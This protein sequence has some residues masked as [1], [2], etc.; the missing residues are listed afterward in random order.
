MSVELGHFA[1]ILAFALSLAQTIVPL[2]GVL[3]RD[4]VLIG[5]ARPATFGT[6]LFVFISFSIISCSFLKSFNFIVMF[7]FIKDSSFF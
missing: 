6:V 4:P 7:A 3:T 1:M 5:T 2:W